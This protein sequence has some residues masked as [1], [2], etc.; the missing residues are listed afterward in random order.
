MKKYRHKQTGQVVTQGTDGLYHSEHGGYTLQRWIFENS[1]DWEE[2]KEEPNYIITAFRSII[3]PDAI[4][5]ITENDTYIRSG[6]VEWT[7]KSMIVD[8][9]VEIY[10]VKNKNGEE[11]T[12]GE[13]VG[14]KINQ[15]YSI[16]TI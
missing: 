12:I 14:V 11:F 3:F 4:W 8:E 15:P 10:S 16:Q 9:A 2:V 1:N 13:E 5:S 6:C 7:L